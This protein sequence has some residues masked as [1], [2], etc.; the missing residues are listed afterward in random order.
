MLVGDTEAKTQAALLAAFDD[1]AAMAPCI[2]YIANFGM[3]RDISD[4]GAAP[5]GPLP[6]APA[7]LNWTA[8]FKLTCPGSLVICRYHTE[9][10][11]TETLRTGMTKLIAASAASGAAVVVVAGVVHITGHLYKTVG[12]ALTCA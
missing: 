9:S 10:P 8:R 7:N 3:L 11:L 12:I 4:A 6:F 1:A 2:L 5:K